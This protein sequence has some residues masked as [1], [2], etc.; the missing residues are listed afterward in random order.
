MEEFRPIILCNIAYKIISNCLANCL[1]GTLGEVISEYEGAF[2]GSRLFQDNAIVYEKKLFGNRSK[3]SFKLD[4]SKA[5]DKVE[6][7]FVEAFMLKSGIDFKW[8]EKIIRCIS[9]VSFRVFLNVLSNM[10]LDAEEKWLIHGLRFGKENIQ[11]FHLFFVNDNLILLKPREK[12][13]EF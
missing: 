6:W 10:I 5:Y 3:V 2:V 7:K 8:V 12:N 9:L 4:M 11:V 1:R 13:A